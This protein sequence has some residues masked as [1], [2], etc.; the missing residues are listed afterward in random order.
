MI[1]GVTGFN[2]PGKLTRAMEIDR[3]F[4]EEDMTVSN[5]LWIEDDGFKPDYTLAKRVGIDYAT[6]EYREIL[7]RFIVNDG[8]YKPAR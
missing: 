6:E 1:R 8:K 2:G 3:S 4:N 7:W 5:R